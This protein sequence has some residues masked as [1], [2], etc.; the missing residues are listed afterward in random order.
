VA[1]LTC[2]AQLETRLVH[3]GGLIVTKLEL[4]VMRLLVRSE[5]LSMRRSEAQNMEK[6]MYALFEHFT[7]LQCLA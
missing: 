3:E 4:E 1:V 6:L 5:C 7:A 2:L